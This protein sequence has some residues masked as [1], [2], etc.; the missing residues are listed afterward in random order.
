MKRSFTYGSKQFVIAH[1]VL[2][3]YD[4]AFVIGR[5]L[6]QQFLVFLCLF[7]V[8][9]GSYAAANFN[10]TPVPG[11]IIPS[12]VP[13]GGIV[14]AYYTVTNNT[15]KTRQDYR[16]EGLPATVH[17]N[18]SNGNCP[19]FIS[20]A[21]GESCI[22]QLDI[23]GF[24][25]SNFGLCKGS[26][27]TTAAVPLNVYEGF[28]RAFSYVADFTNTI[29]QCPLD[30]TGGFNNSTCTALTNSTLPGFSQ[31]LYVAFS[32]FSGITYA[33]V[34]DNS[35]NLWKCAVNASGGF[36]GC[37]ALVNTPDFSNTSS[38]TFYTFSNTTYAYVADSSD[39]LWQCPMNASGDFSSNCTALTN[40]PGFNFVS[41]VTF[42]TFAGTVYGY[43]TDVSDS[44]WKCPMNTSGG[45]SGN[46][47][48]L[49]NST[50]PGFFLTATAIFNTFSNM[51]YAYVTD[52]SANLWQCAI[53]SSGDINGGC[54]ALTNTPN[55]LST[56]VLSFFTIQG[57]T[58]AYLG[59]ESTNIWQCPM[60]PATGTFNGNCFGLGGFN[61]AISA[62]F[63]V[64]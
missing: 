35:S 51:T 39:T 26:N 34:A 31:S 61:H 32:T 59:D 38:V 18:T 5:D 2:R 12:W 64:S 21:S 42:Q 8:A 15:S 28:H 57:T 29:W 56:N 47:A 11:S 27:C 22:L 37:T 45:F 36:D 50:P 63:N 24:T 14:S 62:T 33:Y 52:L 55:F 17:Q 16:I 60:D 30:S 43:V 1:P 25:A 40:A 23:S 41:A 4:R 46:C 13:P 49:T 44:L 20:L 48:A 3:C 6:L 58:Y 9:I 7:F 10:I 54:I 53:N 19:Q